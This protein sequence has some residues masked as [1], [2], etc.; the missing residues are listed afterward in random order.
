[1]MPDG[2]ASPILN[3]E[4]SGCIRPIEIT[5][6]FSLPNGTCYRDIEE[7]IRKFNALSL[8]TTV[9]GLLHESALFYSGNLAG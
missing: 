3:S 8:Q 9:A 2:K 4:I 6:P 5:E 7:D 1:M